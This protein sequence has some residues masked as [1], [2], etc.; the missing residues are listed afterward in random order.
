MCHTRSSKQ[1]LD[2]SRIALRRFECCD[3]HRI[4]ICI[5]LG[6]PELCLAKLIEVFFS[7]GGVI[8]I[9]HTDISRW[10]TTGTTF[11]EVLAVSTFENIHLWKVYTRVIVIIHGAILGTQVLCTEDKEN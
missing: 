11:P 7:R 4:T 9:V 2:G 6:S 8:R 1:R 10:F 3:A 5:R